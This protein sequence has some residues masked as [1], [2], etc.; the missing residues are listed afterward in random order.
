[1]N[2]RHGW[3]FVLAV[4]LCSLM[5]G[6]GVGATVSSQ[7]GVVSLDPKAW[8]VY[9]GNLPHYPTGPSDGAWSTFIPKSPGSLGYVRTPFHSSKTLSSVVMTFRVT[10]SPDVAYANVDPAAG[11]LVMFHLF[12][13]RRGDDMRTPNYR[14]WADSGGYVLGSQDNSIV[15]ISVPL[16]SDKWTNVEGHTDDTEF[17]NA[18]NDLGYVGFTFGGQWSYGHGV[19]LTSGTADFTLIDYRIE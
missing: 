12:L 9:Y 16:T 1:M 13:E 19:N 4:I 2:K 6:C 5:V 18:L 15:T 7:D 14:W 10:S 11:D 8:E 17:H 3:Q